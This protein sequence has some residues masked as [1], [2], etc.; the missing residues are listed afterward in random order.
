[1]IAR[2]GGAL[3]DAVKEENAAAKSEG[4]GVAV[5][6]L[7]QEDEAPLRGKSSLEQLIDEYG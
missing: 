5:D 2:S 6:I 1:M 3:S 7:E 4:V